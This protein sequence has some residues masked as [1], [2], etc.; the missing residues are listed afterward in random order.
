MNSRFTNEERKA[1]EVAAKK[2]A[3]HPF[4]KPVIEGDCIEGLYLGS[5]S[6][7]TDYGDHTV[8]KLLERF[9]CVS[10]LSAYVQ[11]GHAGLKAFY[12]ERGV[13][14]KGDR[15]YWA[16]KREAVLHEPSFD[17]DVPF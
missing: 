10:E 16:D 4:W 17:D 5:R 12:F 7:K 9:L 3:G 6:H 15:L 13:E 8:K 14:R 1:A 11:K 2:N